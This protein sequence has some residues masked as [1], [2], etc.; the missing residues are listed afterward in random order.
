MPSTTDA[1]VP[2][3]GADFWIFYLLPSLSVGGVAVEP[4]EKMANVKNVDSNFMAVL[5]RN[6]IIAMLSLFLINTRAKE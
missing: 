5:K 4:F 3:I 2:T 6:G 1:Q